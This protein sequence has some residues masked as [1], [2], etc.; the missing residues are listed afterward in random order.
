MAYPSPFSLYLDAFGTVEVPQDARTVEI[1][2]FRRDRMILTLTGLGLM[3]SCLAVMWASRE[4]RSRPRVT[5]P[6]WSA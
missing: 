4:S 2:T 5:L 1:S 6:R 3:L